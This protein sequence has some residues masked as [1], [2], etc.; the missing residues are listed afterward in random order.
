M[1]IGEGRGVS[2]IQTPWHLAGLYDPTGISC[3]FG[4][5]LNSDP[6]A[7][8]QGR[9]MLSVPGF[10]PFTHAP[11]FRNG[12]WPAGLKL[13][14]RVAGIPVLSIDAA[15]WGLYG[16][17]TFL[18]RDIVEADQPKLCACDPSRIPLALA[19]HLL[20]PQSAQG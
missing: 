8:A 3:L 15:R 10:L 6:I 14:I 17:M 18:T 16:G 9:G 7:P 2:L 19:Q 11:L 20:R 13:T 5:A 4:F 1:L 12:P